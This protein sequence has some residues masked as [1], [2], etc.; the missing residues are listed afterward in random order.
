ME[1][2]QQGGSESGEKVSRAGGHW[3]QEGSAG[4]TLGRVPF[5]I[6]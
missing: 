6:L 3:H 2:E 1:V 4:T 5:L